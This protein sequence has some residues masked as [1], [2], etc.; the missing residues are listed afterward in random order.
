MMRYA[1]IEN[2]TIVEIRQF[3]REPDP[4]PAEGFDW[5]LYLEIPRPGY[6]KRTHHAPVESTD[7]WPTKVVSTWAD[8]VAKTAQEL[9]NEIIAHAAAIAEQKAVKLAKLI[10]TGQFAQENRIRVLEGK[11]PITVNQYFSGLDS[12]PTIPLA[13]FIQRI[14]TLL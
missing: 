3:D 12:L 4:N 5:R 9:D 14:K 11:A 6:D 8:P 10:M 1:R 2:A 13:D 7:I